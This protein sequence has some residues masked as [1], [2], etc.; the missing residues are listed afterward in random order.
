MYT[1]GKRLY[2]NQYDLLGLF[3]SK[4]G[5]APGSPGTPG[6]SKSLDPP[7]ADQS[8]FYLPLTAVYAKFCFWIGGNQLPRKKKDGGGKPE[9]GEGTGDPP[10][11]FQCTWNEKTGQFFLGA[12]LAGYRSNEEKIDYGAWED[13]V[14]GKRWHLFDNFYGFPGTW[15]PFEEGRSPM[16][17][18][19]TKTTLF[20][21]CGETYPFLEM[22]G[23]GPPFAC[24]VPGGVNMVLILDR[25]TAL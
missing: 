11:C 20:G 16:K 5:P 19:T 21:N 9:K 4:M 6:T 7:V 12:S 2:W 24:P 8:K 15:G 13:V 17:K 18:W 25:V 1:A 10:A 23:Y 22:F 3:F 14:R